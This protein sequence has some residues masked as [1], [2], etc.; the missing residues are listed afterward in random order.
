MAHSIEYYLRML[1]K[2][3]RMVPSG[4]LW[5]PPADVYRTREGWIVK[6]ELAGVS[7]EE[8]T[9]IIAGSELTVSGCRR[10]T[11]VSECLSCHQLEITYSRFEKTISFPCRV[12]G[13]AVE[14]DYR[15]GL[16]VI[17]LRSPR[18]ECE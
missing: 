6:V 3:H 12:E 13:A 4:R 16:L 5:Y 1:P 11:Y 10:D 7:P 2:A 14:R 15:D 18:E 17:H 8:V 9:V